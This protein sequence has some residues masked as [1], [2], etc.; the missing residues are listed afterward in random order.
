MGAFDKFLPQFHV[1][2]SQGGSGAWVKGPEGLDSQI[3]TKNCAAR[4]V[5]IEP[6]DIFFKKSSVAT[7][8]HFRL[9]YSAIQAHLID[10]GVREMH[11]AYRDSR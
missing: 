5:L 2:P 6:G 10:A 4:G 11:F 3:L 1:T 8:S 9:G 7:R